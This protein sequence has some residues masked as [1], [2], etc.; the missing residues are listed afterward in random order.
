VVTSHNVILLVSGD[1]QRH[2]S[3]GLFPLNI[4]H[5][6]PGYPTNYPIGYPGNKL[7]L[8][9]LVQTSQNFTCSRGL[10]LL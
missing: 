5:Q 10:V 4:Y 9:T 8:A 3:M 2:T 6:V 1:I 7:P